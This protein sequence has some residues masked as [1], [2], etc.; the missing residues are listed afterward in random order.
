MRL[1][2]RGGESGI[3]THDSGH[4][5]YRGLWTS[6]LCSKTT[7]DV[8]RDRSLSPVVYRLCCQFCCQLRLIPT[9]ADLIERDCCAVKKY[10]C[11]LRAP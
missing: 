7:P 8:Y 6:T 1:L 11:W 4:L 2:Q 10:L 3:R 5:V 9:F